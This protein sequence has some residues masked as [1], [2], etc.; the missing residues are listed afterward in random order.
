[1]DIQKLRDDSALFNYITGKTNG[2]LAACEATLE[3]TSGYLG[4]EIEENAKLRAEIK[5]LLAAMLR[6]ADRLPPN[7]ACVILRAAL[8][9]NEQYPPEDRK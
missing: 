4:Q 9:G 2:D 1:M 6:A 7:A 3:H 8:G 5:R